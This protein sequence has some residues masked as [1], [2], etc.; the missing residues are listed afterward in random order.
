M[1]MDTQHFQAVRVYLSQSVSD[2][3]LFYSHI[4]ARLVVMLPLALPVSVFTSWSV[5]VFVTVTD[6]WYGLCSPEKD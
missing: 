2:S 6:H 1:K 3:G 4:A 5:V